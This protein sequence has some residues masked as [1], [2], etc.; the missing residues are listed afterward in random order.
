[1]PNVKF[2]TCKTTGL[3]T[4]SL[5]LSL[6]G[7]LTH[8]IEMFGNSW[9]EAE[10]HEARCPMVP[11]DFSSPCAAVDAHVLLVSCLIEAVGLLAAEKQKPA[12][13]QIVMI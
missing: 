10:P 7:V 11:S 12:L 1:M 6:P 4:V 2:K 5:S 9:V 3:D 13:K 8:D